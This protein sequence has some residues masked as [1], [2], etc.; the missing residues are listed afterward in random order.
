VP[1]AR[2]VILL[3]SVF[4]KKLALACLLVLL[5]GVALGGLTGGPASAAGSS[6]S[7]TVTAGGSPVRDCLVMVYDATSSDPV[8]D[9]GALT[10]SNGTYT[11]STNITAGGSYEVQFYMPDG[12]HA[13]EWYNNSPTFM[14][15][16]VV[17]AAPATNINADL[18]APNSIT[19]RVTEEG[20]GQPIRNC[21][22]D[23]Y[24]PT[25]WCWD[26]STTSDADGYYSVNGL[27]QGANYK[28]YF[29]PQEDIHEQI[30]YIEWYNNA[31]SWAR[32]T[33]V[34]APGAD[35]NIELRMMRPTLQSIA[36]TEGTPGS[37]VLLTGNTFGN[38]QGA[39]NVMFGSSKALD[40]V[41]WSNRSITC[42]V[43]GGPVGVVPVT[44]VT[45]GGT[46]ESKDFNVKSAP[47]YLAEGSSDWGF[48]TY[49]TIQNPEPS[50]VDVDVT[51]MTKNGPK[52]VPTMTLPAQSQ[53]VVNPR[54]DLGSTD[55]STQVTTHGSTHQIAV[56][57]RMI[58][59]GPGAPSPEGHSSIGVNAPATT[60]YLPEGSS[61]YG[62]ETWILVQNPN[63]AQANV[64][65]TYMIENGQPVEAKKTVAANSRGSF[66]M[67]ED[68]GAKDASIQVTSDVPVI[69][70]RSMYRNNRREGHDS[71][72]TTSPS[73]TYYLAEG[74][75]G[76]GFTTYILVQNPNDTDANVTLTYMTSDG[77]Q[78]QPAFAMK[79][80]SRKTIR[81]NDTLKSKDFSTLVTGDK[82]IIAERS[83]YWGAGTRS[84]EACH[85]SIGMATPYKTFYL[86]DGETTNG[87]ETWT[88]VQNPNDVPVDIEITY[89][90]PNGQGN[91]V[92][93]QTI[94]A[95]SRKTFFMADMIP[96]GRASIMVTCLTAGKKIM[97]E[98]AMYWNNRGAGTDTIGGFSN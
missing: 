15:G 42:K 60:W 74:T 28:L 82:P 33:S 69:P 70:E 12:S 1:A 96:A 43:P 64:T 72:G 57:R 75:T 31:Y 49:V 35:V 27:R 71:I 66:N 16:N 9:Q 95:N 76:Y 10:G 52:Q 62:F 58:W 38:T 2:G 46:T 23:V 51:Y 14:L 36:P 39:S 5:A 87:V 86:P 4:Q 67:K 41:S 11:F 22:I 18:E 53:T 47:W 61:D 44:V 65:L 97:V 26:F 92:L 59:T 45:P 21:I 55:F 90:T 81:V 20:S 93:G 54:N 89:M 78:P 68:I 6:I 30:H 7:G 48:D 29:Y 25:T 13:L 63:D 8:W 19:G 50:A 73:L 32:A 91:K 80:K 24:D 85:D 56:D 3:G 77:P 40:I 88:L 79:A 84:G 37:T 83:M 98:R 34:L 94:D 17:V